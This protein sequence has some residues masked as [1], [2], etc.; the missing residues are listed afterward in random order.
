MKKA[1]KTTK[2]IIK[3]SEELKKVP[4][5]NY[6]YAFLILVGSILLTFYIFAWINVRKQE[7]ILN[8]YLIESNTVT[9]SLELDGSFKQVVQDAP[10]SYF[11]YV[12]Y[13]KDE[14]IY[15]LEKDLKRVIDKYKINDIFYYVDITDLK[16]NNSE[17]LDY[18]NEKLGV[19][20][21][22][23]PAIIFVKDGQ[24]LDR[25]I[26]TGVRDTDLKADDLESLLEVYEF[27]K[28]K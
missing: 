10:S 12:S 6:I 28:I 11:I 21:S 15:N 16:E 27:E 22:R 18:V 3:K 24:I 25:N 9:S 13:R 7:K 1:T 4:K 26:L 17:Y 14:K 2:K 19:K 5:V 23:V 8:S 20:L